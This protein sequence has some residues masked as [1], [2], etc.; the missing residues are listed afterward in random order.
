[1]A[2]TGEAFHELS[3]VT[4]IHEKQPSR[5]TSHRSQELLDGTERI[6]EAG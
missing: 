5:W 1:M 4:F 2:V 6:F 3:D